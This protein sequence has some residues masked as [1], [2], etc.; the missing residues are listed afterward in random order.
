MFASEIENFADEA[1]ENNEKKVSALESSV[2]FP[3]CA[4]NS[5]CVSGNPYTFSCFTRHVVVRISIHS[6]CYS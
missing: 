2:S 4:C 6:E 1:I 3:T 5:S